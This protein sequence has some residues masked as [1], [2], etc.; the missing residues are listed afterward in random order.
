M[1][2]ESYL[3]KLLWTVVILGVFGYGLYNISLAV[4]DYYKFDVITNIDRV[5]PGNVTF[6]A[7]VICVKNVYFRKH[8]KRNTNTIKED[9]IDSSYDN[10]SRIRN[11]LRYTVFDNESVTSLEMFK[12]REFYD[13]IR[14]NGFK[15]RSVELYRAE[16]TKNFLGVSINTKYIE[17]INENE[18]FIYSFVESRS[19]YS[20]SESP[21]N[22][23]YVSI[24]DNYLN[25]FD[26][27][28]PL[29]LGSENFHKIEIKKESS[30]VKLPAPYN[31]C[32]EHLVNEPYH[33]SNCIEACIFNK[34][35]NKYNCTFPLRLFAVEGLKQCDVKL[36]R[37]DDLRKEFSEG[38]LQQC[39]L[40]SCFTE[41]ITPLVTTSKIY[42]C[43]E[44]NFSFSDMS[45]LNITQIPKTDSFTFLN[46]IGGGLGLFMGIAFPNLI[47]F[48]QFILEIVLIL[49]IKKIK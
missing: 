2:A 14:F 39:P 12:V 17:T 31:D 6:P 35:G 4:D 25:S 45:I 7:I 33:Q 34:I 36:N 28:D 9:S 43:T 27:F 3:I 10:I 29:V 41:K 30:E 1:T 32:K 8:Y 37:Y 5:T 26:K 19:A 22:L 38:C 13:C 20:T 49:L 18:W 40:E 16:S 15:N 23:F 47:E 44:F 46:N 11:F 48:L 24:T 42:N 21:T